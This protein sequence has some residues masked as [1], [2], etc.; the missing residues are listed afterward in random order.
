MGG[1]ENI[2]IL[3]VMRAS[4]GL[5]LSIS[6]KLC[7]LNMCRLL[8]DNYFSM[9]VFLKTIM[10]SVPRWP[11][12]ILQMLFRLSNCPYT[13][14]GMLYVN[15]SSLRSPGLS[16]PWRAPLYRFSKH[17]LP[18]C[19]MGENSVLSATASTPRQTKTDFIIR[20]CFVQLTVDS[21]NFP[22]IL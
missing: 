18:P 15:L 8:C 3:I 19:S 16:S 14:R 6:I 17:E 9:K 2:L 10:K 5:H 4:W 21:R 20:Q 13:L 22:V 11:L 7:T 12:E 1:G